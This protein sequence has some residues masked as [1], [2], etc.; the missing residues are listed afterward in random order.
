MVILNYIDW[1]AGIVAVIS[2]YQYSTVYK[3]YY[4]ADVS[5]NKEFIYFNLVY[6]IY[7]IPHKPEF[8]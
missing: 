2:L 6:S 1:I 5:Y 7:I 4:L 8:E 3:R